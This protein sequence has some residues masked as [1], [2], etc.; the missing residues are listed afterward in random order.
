[1]AYQ[2]M[3][4]RPIE[5]RPFT[6]ADRVS[7]TPWFPPDG[8]GVFVPDRF[9]AEADERPA[10]V[11]E[12]AFFVGCRGGEPVS[13]LSFHWVADDRAAVSIAVAPNAR[14][15]GVATATLGALRDRFHEINEFVAFVHPENAPSL[16]LLERLGLVHAGTVKGP[17]ELFVWRRDGSPLPDGWR[18]PI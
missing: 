1:M 4:K 3:P 8:P 6:E 18:P 17:R 16:E 11:G 9:L 15:G 2:P 13:L 14:R 7:L 12:M 10:A 5:L